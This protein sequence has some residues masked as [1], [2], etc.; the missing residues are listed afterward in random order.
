MIDS[1][2]KFCI[3]YVVILFSFMFFLF[4]KYSINSYLKSSCAISYLSVV[5]N[6]LGCATATM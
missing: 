3:L 5:N 2:G 1:C 4:F 6:F